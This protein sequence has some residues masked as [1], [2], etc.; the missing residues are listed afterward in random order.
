MEIIKNLLKDPEYYMPIL[1]IVILIILPILSG[2]FLILQQT[3]YLKMSKLKFKKINIYIGLAL[4]FFGL[5]V[6]LIPIKV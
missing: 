3:Y 1:A 4:V 2:L 6:G 5:V